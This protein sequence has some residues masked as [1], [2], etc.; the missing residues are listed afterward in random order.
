MEPPYT[1]VTPQ[2]THLTHGYYH[3]TSTCHEIYDPATE[4]TQTSLVDKQI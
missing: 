4:G 2:C 3:R 1:I